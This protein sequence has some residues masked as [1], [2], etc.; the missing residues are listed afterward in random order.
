MLLPTDFMGPPPGVVYHYSFTFSDAVLT[1]TGIG[2][3]GKG[4]CLMREEMT[5]TTRDSAVKKDIR[6][7]IQYV[8]GPRLMVAPLPKAGSIPALICLDL[9]GNRWGFPLTQVDT[10]KQ[11]SADCSIMTIETHQL[12]GMMRTVLTVGGKYCMP[13]KYASGIGLIEEADMHLTRI[14][15]CTKE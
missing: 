12:F 5:T 4:G 10:G 6:E 2:K 11:I 9:S 8:D 1:V 7:Y 13:R 3:D 15:R 14:Q